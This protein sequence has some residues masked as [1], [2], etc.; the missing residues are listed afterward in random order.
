MFGTS[1]TR[2]VSAM[3][4]SMVTTV[5]V[6]HPGTSISISTSISS[7]IL[8]RVWLMPADVKLL[9]NFVLTSVTDRIFTG[10]FGRGLKKSARR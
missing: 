5:L 7:I 1:P 9:V 2:T 8:C 6:V 3:A 10:I 4:V